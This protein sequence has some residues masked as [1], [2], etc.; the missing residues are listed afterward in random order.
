MSVNEAAQ[1]LAK[2]LRGANWLHAV[3]VGKEA[4]NECIYLYVKKDPPKDLPDLRD[5]GDQFPVI[6]RKIG[7]IR[8]ALSRSPLRGTCH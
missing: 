6:I 3:A 5:L 4:G 2:R 8:P 7:A 1:R